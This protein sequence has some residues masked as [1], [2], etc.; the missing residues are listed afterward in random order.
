MNDEANDVDPFKEHL[1]FASP[2][3]S[4]SESDGLVGLG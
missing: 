4:G 2:T 3:G 1:R